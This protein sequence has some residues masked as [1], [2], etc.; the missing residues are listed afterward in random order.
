MIIELSHRGKDLIFRSQSIQEEFEPY[1]KMIE[2]SMRQDRPKEEC[3]FYKEV[4][5]FLYIFPIKDG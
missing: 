4:P 1:L 3:G 2:N 5:A